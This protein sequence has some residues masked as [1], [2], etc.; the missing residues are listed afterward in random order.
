MNGTLLPAV[1]YVAEPGAHG[2]IGLIAD[3]A[4][5]SIVS[6]TVGRQS[7][8]NFTLGASRQVTL[9]G[10][11][12][13]LSAADDVSITVNGTPV[14]LTGAQAHAHLNIA[15]ATLTFDNVAAIPIGGLVLVT[16]VQ[17]APQSFSLPQIAMTDNDTVDATG[18]TLPLVIFGGQGIDHLNGGTGGD[19]IFGDRGRALYFDPATLLPTDTID[20][21]G[22]AMLEAAAKTVY[23]HGGPGDK[24]DAV[25]RLVGL[26]VGI[27]PTI[28]DNDTITDGTGADIVI[29]GIGND[30][31]TA[32]SGEPALGPDAADIVIGD[33]GFVDYAVTDHNATTLDRVWTTDPGTGGIDTITTGGSSDVV[34]G[35]DAGDTITAGNGD[36]VVLGDNGKITLVGG[37]LLQVLSTS[38]GLDATA[39]GGVETITS[40]AGNDTVV[41]GLFGDTIVA[42]DGNNVVIG[43]SGEIDYQSGTGILLT[44][45]SIA[46]SDGGGDS[47]TTGVGNDL[48][49]GG[50]GADTIV[51]NSGETLARPDGIDIVVGDNG[52]VVY[53]GPDN[54]LATLDLVTTTFPAAGGG[55]DQ[56]TT[57]ASG[58]VIIGGDLGDTIVAGN[59]DN[60]VLGD[61]GPISLFAGKLL[62]VLSTETSSLT[63]HGGADTITTGTGNDTVVGGL[64]GDTIAV[65]DGNNVVFGDSAHLDYQSSTGILLT[66]TSIDD[67]S[68]GNDTIR[69]GAGQDI[70]VGGTGNDMVDGGA[71]SDVVIGDNALLN[72]SGR[73]GDFTSPLFRALGGT[74]IYDT[75]NG[76][77]LVTSAPQLDP[78]GA[79]WWSD[80]QL[81]LL[82]LGSLATAG[83]Y[84]D[85]YLAGG[86]GNDLI[87]GQNG[88]DVIQ[89]DGSIDQTGGN[90]SCGSSTAVGSGGQL[91]K[92]LVGAC[93]GVGTD[94]IP[95]A[96]LV[97]PSADHLGTD[98]NDYIEGGA[99]S[100]V[101]FG[102]QGQDNIIGGS[103]NVFGQ[104]STQTR[105]DGSN[106]LFGGSG[107]EISRSDLG[108][109]SPNGHANDADAIVANN[110]LILDLVGT[111]GTSSG[112]FLTFNYDN[113]AGAT[114]HVIPRAVTLL[115][116]TPGGPTY[117]PSLAALDVVAASEIHGEA[118]DDVIYGGGGRDVLY[119]DAQND[120][121]G[122]GYDSD[123]IDGGT[124]DD[125]LLGDDGRIFVSRIS[126]SYGE[127]LYGIV[128]IDP[129]QIDLLISN[130][131]GAQQA[132]V[133]PNGSLK[134]T[135]FLLPDNLDPAGFT[136]GAQDPYYRP[137]VGAAND[138]IYGGV[139]D[140]SIHGGA[141][142]DA[143]SGAEAPVESYTNNYN[144]N[145]Q[146]VAGQTDLRSD[147]YHPFNPGNVLGYDPVTTDARFS[148]FA[149]YD[150]NN[151]LR[152]ILLTPGTGALYGGPINGAQQ[153]TADLPRVA[154]RLRL[155]RRADRHAV[156]R[157]PVD[158]SGRS[159][160]R[161]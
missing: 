2:L 153:N 159:D 80:F 65:S 108:D 11:P 5:G 7:V 105:P 9:T 97:T 14:A 1:Q 51:A 161:Q 92:T 63:G 73:L 158:V 125:G 103:S 76:Q 59:G 99:G 62:Q 121:I 114:M 33:T 88:N 19:V 90:L 37:K 106:M 131:S 143:I 124:G 45:F 61:N 75:T 152:E 28:G 154:A 113:G 136:G 20:A 94:G 133:N 60:Q 126:S 137:P 140:D 36:N 47:I 111:N 24:T 31:I 23:G 22:L 156:D 10:L 15:T 130:S 160:G 71:G 42:G 52:Q 70:L 148:M 146:P 43:D 74:Q 57:G 138:I 39:Q 115:D 55:A 29:G 91:F 119:G 66:A 107:T 150:N 118:G 8:R 4:N 147:W 12:A 89:G 18:S 50:I 56:I 129:S 82:D 3:P 49:L 27:D 117:A 78:Q 40:G 112:H 144:A 13:T 116:Y 141:G 128:P 93:R 32:N 69:S 38:T 87:F 72:R 68:G 109:G 83:S 102:N 6:V 64:F 127:P 35:G 120:V 25:S 95:N 21:A 157:R 67:V 123:W 34:I 149:L 84:G 77:A 134:Y 122:G 151:P 44:A 54:N 104:T 30:I 79:S 132:I 46:P 100:D 16:V 142:D 26:A 139:G 135:A 81:T 86:A 96:L 41:G 17:F 101:V 98:G 85:D 155:H 145:G 110:G 53:N 58:D 48:I